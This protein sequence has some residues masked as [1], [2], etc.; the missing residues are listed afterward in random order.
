MLTSSFAIEAPQPRPVRAT[1]LR[2]L[3]RLKHV[4]ELLSVAPAV[5][6]RAMQEIQESELLKAFYTESAEMGLL[7]HR[8]L[9]VSTTQE[10]ERNMEAL[11]WGLRRIAWSTKRL[12]MICR[13]LRTSVVRI[14]RFVRAFVLKVLR[15]KKE[16][17]LDSWRHDIAVKVKTLDR[18]TVLALR[19]YRLPPQFQLEQV[20]YGMLADVHIDDVWLR[21]A[22][23]SLW[24]CRKLEYRENFARQ[25]SAGRADAV[26]RL[27][28]AAAAAVTIVEE[29]SGLQRRASTLEARTLTFR[30]LQLKRIAYTAPPLVFGRS[31]ATNAELCSHLHL[32]RQRRVRDAIERCSLE[33]A[34][35]GEGQEILATPCVRKLSDTEARELARLLHSTSK[36]RVPVSYFHA[37]TT[38]DSRTQWMLLFWLRRLQ[39][40]DVPIDAM[41]SAAVPEAILSELSEAVRILRVWGHRQYPGTPAVYERRVGNARRAVD[42]HG[43]PLPRCGVVGQRHASPPPPLA[44]A[45]NTLADSRHVSPCRESAAVSPMKRHCTSPKDATPAVVNAV[46]LTAATP[47]RPQSAKVRAR[48]QSASQ[49][50]ASAARCVQPSAS[51]TVWEV[52][53]TH[54]QAVASKARRQ[55]ASASAHQ[56]AV[57]DVL[58]EKQYSCVRDP[59]EQLQRRLHYQQPAAT[60]AACGPSDDLEGWK[61]NWMKPPPQSASRP[62]TAPRRRV[63]AQAPDELLALI[64]TRRVVPH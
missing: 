22:V 28:V 25:Q 58:R 53:L 19:R 51:D 49:R 54:H 9:S 12:A 27:S 32:L 17:V 31:N 50:P 26:R 40:S 18:Q 38:V 15:A 30:R 44:D 57:T 7:R 61:Q 5:T 52:A 33:A 43:Q 11:K 29:R 45:G 37:L 59:N 20:A 21:A 10:L 47:V 46:Q 63:D 23:E 8:Y 34:I 48:P 3:C 36:H 4:N 55:I 16:A 6:G 39:R 64:A 56:M 2:S 13:W 24:L 41:I 35:S 1:S 42:A 62:V 14:Q 60:T